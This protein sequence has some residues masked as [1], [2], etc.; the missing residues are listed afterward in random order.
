MQQTTTANPQPIILT[1]QMPEDFWVT[2]YRTTAS[3]SVSAYDW[4]RDYPAVPHSITFAVDYKPNRIHVLTS[5]PPDQE[6]RGWSC[7]GQWPWKKSP[8]RQRSRIFQQII[9]RHFRGRDRQQLGSSFG[10]TSWIIE[11]PEEIESPDGVKTNSWLCA[12]FQYCCVEGNDGI[13]VELRR[14]VQASQSMWEEHQQGIFVFNEETN[15][16]R[17]KVAVATDD[18]RMS[19]GYFKSLTSLNL[20]DPAYSGTTLS[21]ADYWRENGHDYSSEEAMTI[22]QVELS[23]RKRYPADKVFRV[24]TMDQWSDSVRKHMEKYLHLRPREYVGYVR[25]AMTWL[26]GWRLYDQETSSEIDLTGN[27]R[28]GWDSNLIPAFV[29]TRPILRLGNGHPMLNR[30]WRWNHHLRRF[31]EYHDS[32]LPPIDVHFVVPESL[33]GC[34]PQLEEH[35]RGI[36]G[37]IPNWSDSVE[38]NPTPHYIPEDSEAL[39]TDSVLKLSRLISSDERSVVVFSATLPK[40]RKAAVNLYKC[41]KYNLDEA[42]I[43]HQNFA[44]RSK[45]SLKK[46]PD[47]TSHQVNVLQ[48]LLKLGI[49]PVPFSCTVGDIDVIVSL[50]VGRIGPNE[51]VAACAVSITNSG[52]LWG[53]TPKAEPQKGENISVNALRRTV[54]KLIQQYE[55]HEGS[56][57][58]RILFIR[59]GNTPNK[60][61]RAMES[62][63]EDYRE[64]LGID[65]CWVSY[66]KSGT[67]RLLIF[68]GKE[69]MDEIPTKGHWLSLSN[70]SAWVWTTGA[71]HLQPGRPGIPQG[72][73]FTIENNFASNPLSLEETA[74]LMISHC[75]ASQTQ[76]WNSTR[77]PFVLHLADKMAKAMV[78]GEIPLNQNGDRFSAV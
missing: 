49:L 8:E 43:V 68:D 74:Q 39:A 3:K 53:T 17:V 51:S 64:S 30:N 16:V 78:N 66:R 22:L 11:G 46:R 58:R 77:L 34:I 56:K 29:D 7:D 47:N 6:I 41:L 23:N 57:P 36:F 26:L 55:H 45:T 72:A 60:E 48:I 32:P 40:N 59:D 73:G 35:A 67:P 76:P 27:T 19:S 2:T 4:N 75:H 28:F 13:I 65:I 1:W 42:G 21:M 63:I 10:R 9:K 24:M 31:N 20:D 37:Q 33:R 61:L 69:V 14:K 5:S 12:E 44:A 70:S 25:K 38:L 15:L 54:S 50:D 52:R 71:P 62:I 18:S